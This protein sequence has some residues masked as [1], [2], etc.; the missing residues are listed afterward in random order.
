M[1]SHINP[2]FSLINLDALLRTCHLF[3][4]F[5]GL[6]SHLYVDF[7]LKKGI[8]DAVGAMMNTAKEKT[9]EL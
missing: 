1:I 8:C 5:S 9:L 2:K 7:I 4:A 6:T 3:S